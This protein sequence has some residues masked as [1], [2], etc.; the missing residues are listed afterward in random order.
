M[1]LIRLREFLY[2]GKIGNL[3]IYYTH[4]GRKSTVLGI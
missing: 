4:N 2:N 3:E 1:L